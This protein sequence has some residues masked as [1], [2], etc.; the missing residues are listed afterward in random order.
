M[1]I[2]IYKNGEWVQGEPVIGERCRLV[3]PSSVGNIYEESIYS[4]EVMIENDLQ[5]LKAQKV[6]AIKAQARQRIE[7][8]DWRLERAKE[9]QALGME[10]DSDNSLE[11]VL[12]VMQL[13]EDIRAASGEAE[14][15]VQAM[16]DEDAIQSFDW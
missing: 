4:P 3:T 1:M 14:L 9:R 10:A 7:A 5:H 12:D 6:L 13:R 2:E 16:E 15:A 8:L 11:T